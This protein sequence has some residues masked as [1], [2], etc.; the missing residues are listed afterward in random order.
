MIV[1]DPSAF[2]KKGMESV[3]VQRQWCGRLGKVENCQVATCMG[4]ISRINHTLIDTRLYLPKSW[5]TD[6][7]RCKKAGVPKEIR[8]QTRHEHA[9]EM[10]DAYGKKLPHAWI[11]GDDE[12]GKCSHFRRDLNDRG[13]RYLLSVP[14]NTTIR[15]LEK[16]GGISWNDAAARKR[17]FQ[18]VQEWKNNLSKKKWNKIEVRDAEKGPLIVEIVVCKVQTKINRCNMKYNEYLVIVRTREGGGK[19]KY[20]YYF[21]NASPGTEPQEYARVACAAHQIEECIKRGKSEAGL[22]DYE[23]RNWL[24]WHHHQVLSILAVWFLVSETERGKKMDSCNHSSSNSRRPGDG[25]VCEFELPDNRANN[26]RQN[27]PITPQRRSKILSPQ[28]P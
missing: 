18:Q 16:P 13:E 6:R 17:P 21:S 27:S 25:A 23:V 7:T 24:G 26:P 2:P 22:A 12:M 14:S 9:L 19:F 3:G 15:D 20:D 8:F 5:T 4:Y 1:F 28:K 10:L 11:A